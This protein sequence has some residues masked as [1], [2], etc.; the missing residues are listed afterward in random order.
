MSLL[1]YK[2]NGT[3]EHI[4]GLNGQADLVSGKGV[5]VQNGEVSQTRDQLT[6]TG[7]RNE[8]DSLSLEQKAQ[9]GIANITDD[10]AS[11]VPIVVDAVT[12][13]DMN[14][15]TSNA[16]FDTLPNMVIPEINADVSGS[17]N[18]PLTIAV[19]LPASTLAK[20][21]SFR[22]IGQSTNGTPYGDNVNTDFFYQVYKIGDSSY[23]SITAYDVRSKRTFRN[24]RQGGTWLGWVSIS[25]DSYEQTRY[26]PVINTTY[27]RPL[28]AN[29]GVSVYK[30]VNGL[31]VLTGY[32]QTNA[33]LVAGVSDLFVFPEACKQMRPAQL[34]INMVSISTGK[35]YPLLM[36]GTQLGTWGTY[37][38]EE[39]DIL[40]IPPVTY[41]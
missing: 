37:F 10:V 21:A 26:D 35:N 7:T 36:A 6:F 39:N 29:D 14:P 2:D 34:W 11:G 23:I 41:L 33:D 3:E 38:P 19:N 4:A 17:P 27:V 32:F 1:F 5:I 28:V 24:S 18:N 15:V 40:F 16:V 25:Q 31:K 12:N 20:F 8:W 9:Y 13:G 22:L 30:T